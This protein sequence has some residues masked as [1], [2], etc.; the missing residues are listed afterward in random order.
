[1]KTLQDWKN[2]LSEENLP[3][4]I[5]EDS[6]DWQ[7][8]PAGLKAKELGIPIIDNYGPDNAK[9]HSLGCV[10]HGKVFN[11]ANINNSLE[12]RNEWR[13]GA[14]NTLNE[15]TNFQKNSNT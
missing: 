11:A 8:C 4:N 15:I 10:F 1:M 2:I 13:R 14:L 9:L 6:F 5:L 12:E 7:T 3:E